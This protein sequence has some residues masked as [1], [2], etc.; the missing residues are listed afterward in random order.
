MA[1]AKSPITT[2]AEA[3]NASPLLKGARPSVPVHFGR[4]KI[5]ETSGPRR[6]VVYCAGGTYVFPEVNRRITTEAPPLCDIDQNMIAKVWAEN[7]DEAWDIQRRFFQALNRNTGRGGPLYKYGDQP[8]DSDDDGGSQGEQLTIRFRLQL[9]IER[10]DETT[11]EVESVVETTKLVN[12]AT[13]E[14]TSGPTITI[15]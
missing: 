11:V 15:T 5:T 8:D 14:E 10:V 2:L 13:E 9:P 6:I 7:H 1:A 4:A 12:P 3:L